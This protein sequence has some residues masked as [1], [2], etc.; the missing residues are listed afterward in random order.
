MNHDSYPDAY[1]AAIL[2]AARTFAFVGASPNTS[3]PSYFV[4]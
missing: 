1:I 2:G 4:M 3:R